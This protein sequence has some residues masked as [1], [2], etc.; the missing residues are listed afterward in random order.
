M[1]PYSELK[2]KMIPRMI[3]TEQTN[4]TLEQTQ[5]IRTNQTKRV[6]IPECRHRDHCHHEQRLLD[7]WA[8]RAEREVALP[9]A[10]RLYRKK[11]Q[12]R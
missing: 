8:L 2:T 5:Q 9:A 7:T 3:A 1:S 4:N 6:Y 10:E 11:K 12:T